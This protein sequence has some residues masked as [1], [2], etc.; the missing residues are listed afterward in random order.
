MLVVL[1]AVQVPY[2]HK[3]YVVRN[4]SFSFFSRTSS[5]KITFPL[6]FSM[7]FFRGKTYCHHF[8][9]KRTCIHE[10]TKGTFF[11]P[12]FR[13]NTKAKTAVSSS[14]RINRVKKSRQGRRHAVDVKSLPVSRILTYIERLI[15]SRALTTGQNLSGNGSVTR[16]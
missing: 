8:S 14:L 6:S 3:M 15:T 7:V 13:G 5:L 10:K 2:S 9:Q 1:V 4:S 12:V 16:I 11:T